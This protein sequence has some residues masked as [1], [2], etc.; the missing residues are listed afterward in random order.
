MTAAT[1]VQIV[2]WGAKLVSFIVDLVQKA[3]EQA[4]GGAAPSLDELDK[5]LAAHQAGDAAE[6]AKRYAADVADAEARVREAAAR[7]YSAEL[8]QVI[9]EPKKP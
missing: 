8:K 9:E 2:A 4:Q 5:R 6:R 3:V 7:E 1:V